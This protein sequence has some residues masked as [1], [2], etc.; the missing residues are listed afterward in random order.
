MDPS[1]GVSV[2]Q[3]TV[4]ASEPVPETENLFKPAIETNDH[5]DQVKLS[6]LIVC[7]YTRQRSSEEPSELSLPA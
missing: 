2:E 5:D 3:E 7:L 6:L 4:S 1:L